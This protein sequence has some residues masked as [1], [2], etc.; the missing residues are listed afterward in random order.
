MDMSNPDRTHGGLVVA[1]GLKILSVLSVI[2]GLLIAVGGGIEVSQADGNPA[3]FVGAVFGATAVGAL[4]FAFL[5]YALEMLVDIGQATRL[6]LIRDAGE[7]TAPQ[8]HGP[9]LRPENKLV[10]AISAAVICLG[11][12][13]VGGIELA[14]NT[15]SSNTMAEY[16]ACMDRLETTY[17]D[18]RHLDPNAD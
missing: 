8:R 12:I 10:A 9:G 6:G 5:G 17:A 7:S 1:Q 2:G 15:G 4:L 14:T 3:E 18:C 13:V 16:S 11:M